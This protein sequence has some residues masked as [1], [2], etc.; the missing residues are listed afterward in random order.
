MTP[1]ATPPRREGHEVFAGRLALVASLRAEGQPDPGKRPRVSVPTPSCQGGL[2]GLEG[3]SR[4]E[5]ALRPRPGPPPAPFASPVLEQPWDFLPRERPRL[6]H[7][8]AFV[9]TFLL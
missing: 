9:G 5:D 2:P 8:G 7:P 3:L 6:I 1:L 4:P